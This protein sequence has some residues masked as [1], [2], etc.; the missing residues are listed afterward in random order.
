MF[1]RKSGYAFAIIVISF[2][3]LFLFH[4]P[5]LRM[6][7]HWI[8]INEEPHHSEAVVVLCSGVEYYPRLIEAAQLFNRGI[9]KKI[10]INGN[11]KTDEIRELEAKG[12]QP[13]CAWYEDSLRVLDVFNVPRS[14]IIPI[15]MEDA[16]D[17]IS[18]AKGVG[19]VV[20]SRGIGQIILTT[21]KYHT[22][23]AL[24]IW[25]K[26]YKNKLKIS[27]VA[28]NKDPYDPDNWWKDGRQIRWLMAEYGAWI[29]LAWKN[30]ME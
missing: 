10:I 23:R 3:F 8:V 16:Y 28:A 24:Y 21:S 18:E 19:E 22:R 20:I 14:A 11:R 9:V 25:K 13:C 30:I 1:S 27:M 4:K 2:L 5:V 29:Y 12:Y 17:T 6:I 7:G 26:L 15:S